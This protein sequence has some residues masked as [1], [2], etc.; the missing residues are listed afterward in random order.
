MGHDLDG[1]GVD[2]CQSMVRISD[3]KL[4][5]AVDK[6]IKLKMVHCPYKGKGCQVTMKLKEVENHLKTVCQFQEEKCCSC[7]RMFARSNLAAHESTCTAKRCAFS[8]V[9][10]NDVSSGGEI[11]QSGGVMA[12]IGVHFSLLYQFLAAIKSIAEFKTKEYN[13]ALTEQMRESEGIT[14]DSKFT[15]LLY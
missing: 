3:L 9:G 1:D 8:A 7:N 10:C 15:F 14:I 6:G 12:D 13:A 2:Q 4:N 5:K 11:G